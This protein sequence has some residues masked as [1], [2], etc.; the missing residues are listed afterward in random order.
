MPSTRVGLLSWGSQTNN[1]KPSRISWKG[2]DLLLDLF[3]GARSLGHGE[4]KHDEGHVQTADIWTM[5]FDDGTA[6]SH[7][8]VNRNRKDLASSGGSAAASLPSCDIMVLTDGRNRYLAGTWSVDR[9]SASNQAVPAHTIET[10][11]SNDHSCRRHNVP[12]I[13][14]RENLSKTQTQGQAFSSPWARGWRVE[15][16]RQHRFSARAASH[17]KFK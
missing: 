4:S 13:P 5:P 8:A 14:A 16:C 11:T 1:G 2:S 10:A 12:A 17:R 6:D 15:S 7:C 9:L 3:Q